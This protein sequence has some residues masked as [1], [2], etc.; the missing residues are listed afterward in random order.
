M[1]RF[2]VGLAGRSAAKFDDVN[3]RRLE[4]QLLN[5]PDVDQLE[6]L[7]WELP[8]E[9]P[10]LAPR[11]A[12]DGQVVQAEGDATPFFVSRGVAHA[13]ER[14]SWLSCRV[15]ERRIPKPVSPAELR[16][17]PVGEAMI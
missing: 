7:L 9:V 1:S 15:G 13:I 17:L 3:K 2:N 16:A 5:H 14:P 6:I 12:L 10:A 11:S 4:E 8:W